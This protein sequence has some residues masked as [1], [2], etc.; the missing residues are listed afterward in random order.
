MPSKPKPEP[1]KRRSSD[2]TKAVYAMYG[3]VVG[4]VLMIAGLVVILFDVLTGEGTEA[5][6]LGLGIGLVLLGGT[7]ALP[8]TFMPILS[9]VLKKIPGRAETITPPDVTDIVPKDDDDK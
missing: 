6:I 7:A 2:T 1:P 5:R 3:L 4:A 9:A 8:K